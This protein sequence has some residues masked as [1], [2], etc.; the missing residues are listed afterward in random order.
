M[1]IQ[2]WRRTLPQVSCGINSNSW[3]TPPFAL[4]SLETSTF[5]SAKA[6]KILI[7]FSRTELTG[8]IYT[9]IQCDR[10]VNRSPSHV[11]KETKVLITSNFSRI[12]LRESDNIRRR[13]HLQQWFSNTASLRR[14]IIAC[15]D[16]TKFDID[17]ISN[18][19]TSK[20]LKTS[21]GTLLHIFSLVNRWEN[22]MCCET[23]FLHRE[24]LL[25]SL[26]KTTDVSS[27]LDCTCWRI[28]AVPQVADFTGTEITTYRH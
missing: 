15:V 4:N 21:S 24:V 22:C 8:V 12:S 23:R 25:T 19:H 18:S 11:I 17:T 5:R 20:L 13:T 3:S 28:A 27:W 6:A 9:Q 2:H 16:M 7:E 26:N 10:V 1:R 14:D